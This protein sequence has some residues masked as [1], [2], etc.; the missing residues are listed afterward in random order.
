M[1]VINIKISSLSIL[2][3]AADQKPQK[4]LRGDIVVILRV[5]Y[6][7]VIVITDTHTQPV[8]GSVDFV[9]RQPG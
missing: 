7:Y 1:Y 2:L 8:Y 4:S 3:M 6:C 5:C 9:L